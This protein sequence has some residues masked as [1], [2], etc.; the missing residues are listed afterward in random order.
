MFVFFFVF[1]FSDDV[2]KINVGSNDDDIDENRHFRNKKAKLFE[3]DSN[4]NQNG[5]EQNAL[6]PVFP[7]QQ[8]L[9]KQYFNKA[10][11][12]YDDI[13]E[14]VGNGFKDSTT[15]EEENKEENHTI[16][17]D[18]INSE[19]TLLSI[20][21]IRIF[22]S[23]NQF[24]YLELEPLNY[25]K[26]FAKFDFEVAPCEK[27]SD[28]MMLCKSPI[29]KPGDVRVSFS[30]DNVSWTNSIEI[31]VYNEEVKI[32]TWIIYP[33]V[34]GV[35]FLAALSFYV[36]MSGGCNFDEEKV[37]KPDALKQLKKHKIQV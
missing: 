10:P 5:V 32:T 30:K 20:N 2:H 24:I 27:Y 3:K 31:Y 26:G 16:I 35:M 8:E 18:D 17:I 6:K 4:E 15:H 28:K 25:E 11:I 21:P 14:S 33:I 34:C 29:L 36:Y 19:I 12:E 37:R 23:K 9:E 22:G 7:G 1:S 13:F